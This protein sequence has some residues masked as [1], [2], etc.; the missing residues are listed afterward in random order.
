MRRDNNANAMDF[1]LQAT[2]KL[3][4]LGLNPAIENLYPIVEYPVPKGTQS[5]SSLIKWD[6]SENWLVTQYPEYF[7]HCSSSD[8]VVTVDVS[9]I[10]DEYLNDH[11]IDGRV[12]YPATGYLMLAWKMLAKARNT[13]YD[14]LAVE[15][16]NVS[17]HRATFLSKTGKTKFVVS[18]ME[19][20][21][22]FAVSEGSAIVAKGRIFVPENPAFEFEHLIDSIT[23]CKEDIILS[24]KDM[25]KELRVRGFDFGPNF[26]LISEA[27]GDARS[28]KVKWNGSWISF[29]DSL[30]QTTILGHKNRGVILPVRFQSVR[31]DPKL[32]EM[33]V[34]ETPVMKV[35][36][37]L[38][39]NVI[40]CKGLEIRGLKLNT[41]PRRVATSAPS[42]ESHSFIPYHETAVLSRPD[43]D[44]LTDYVQVCTTVAAQVARSAG[45]AS[46]A[47]EI[48]G[49][50]K[51]ASED[52]VQKMIEMP[53]EERALLTALLE[54]READPKSFDSNLPIISVK[55]LKSL[56]HDVLNN[57]F[58]RE[59]FLRPSLDVVCEN[60]GKD[61]RI[62][63]LNPTSVLLSKQIMTHVSHYGT[64]VRYTVAH[65]CPSDVTVPSDDIDITEWSE[66]RN[67]LEHGSVDLAVYKDIS[68]NAGSVSKYYSLP[69]VL[70][71]VTTV[72]KNNGFVF[73]IFR[74]RVTRAESFLRPSEL[75]SSRLDEFIDEA[76]KLGLVV[77]SRKSDSLA[78]STVLLR[79]PEKA[80]LS[81]QAI[82]QVSGSDFNWVED[83]KSAIKDHQCK[84]IGENIWLVAQEPESNGILG[85]VTC[86]RQESGG[87]R[88]RCIFDCEK[89]SVDLKSALYCDILQADLVQNVIQNGVR[90]SYRHINLVEKYSNEVETEHA[91]LS[92]LTRGDLSTLKWVEAQHKHWAAGHVSEQLAH[93]YFAPINFRDV[94]LATGKLPPDALPGDMALQ[95]CILGL[96]FA[97]RDATG[98]RIM[99]MVPCKGLAT[100]VVLRDPDFIWSIPDTWSMEEAATVPV[101]YSTAYYALIV[102][103]G[104]QPG[105]SV[106][107]HS[108][109]GGVGQ[110]AI[111]IC[112]SMGCL[113][114]TTIGSQDKRNVLKQA[115]PELQERNFANSRDT[116][117]EQHIL[118]ET[119]G[120][121][122][123]LVLNS[124][125]EE[126]LQASV[127]CLAQD[128]RFLEIGKYDLSQNNPLGMSAFLKNISFHGILLETLF[129]TR[130]NAAP[131]AVTR[132][133]LV[134][135]L[136]REGIDT[137][138]VR[139]L[140]RTIFTKE[141]SEEAFRYMA[142][143]KHVGK[144]I[145]RLQEEETQST[146][147]PSSILVSAISRTV[148][149]RVK[150]AYQKLTIKRLE[151]FGVNVILSNVNAST[152][153]G[154]SELIKIAT[155]LGPVGG[156]FNT[157]LV[158]RDSSFDNQSAETFQDVCAPK[159]NAT[160]NLDKVTRARCPGLD[161][162][163]CF[164]SISCGRGNAGQTNYGFANSVMERICEARQQEGLPAIA[165]QWG[166]IG[167][168]GVVAET[169]GNDAIINCY[170]AQR[171]PSCLSALDR[172]LQSSYA[173]TSSYI[174][175]ETS[176]SPSAIKKID[177]LGVVAHILG[178]KNVSTLS[179]QSALSDLG[180]DSLM[181]VE[182]KQT[183]ERDYDVFLPMAEIRA[184][185]VNDLKKLGKDSSA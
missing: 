29:V 131:A 11:C 67:P 100:T 3:Y 50:T 120:L 39:I 22:D 6:H 28:A 107:I 153:D 4:Q 125:C 180:L 168:V 147:E 90:G 170:S 68:T 97:G 117:F 33:A 123:D 183:L 151:T 80:L 124:L 57:T 139:P 99:G 8:H 161:Y 79:K 41:A 116:S 111:S 65:P 59:R 158:L 173:V 141:Q 160:A 56:N 159:A 184:L 45:K 169:M 42:F 128:G 62:L 96:E 93:V 30:M 9:E 7:N 108:G 2:G 34:R 144:V 66:T 114:F 76:Q 130:V 157:A 104:L 77:V 64:H 78:A 53:S 136:L 134:S 75:S 155:K 63:E 72:L 102:R 121:G 21:G 13:S 103:G 48:L 24:H 26:R 15:F 92:V 178:I 51:E 71:R 142:S 135:K 137:G 87:S 27:T 174:R 89:N 129:N 54:L 18:L 175:V 12:L 84:P 165:I 37:D 43:V 44:E 154:A 172:F 163:V 162:F 19:T 133:Q 86:L 31:C 14:K 10:E 70:E 1:L 149:K 179:G 106:L 85:L 74:D 182:V 20:S 181:G 60:S 32:L 55:H 36:A 112:L 166:V 58:L 148:L 140:K 146:H 5:I 23:P 152:L 98:R 113:V 132:K 101:V 118:H 38:C 91:H 94:M 25:Y 47:D 177:L 150:D 185:T 126:K 52:L 176:V 40:L 167:D 17:F 145:I 122:V 35:V 119:E 127:R 115:F 49:N 109:S 171:I 156:V 83:V 61:L 16:E 138:A 82:I 46:M 105:E 81:A 73:A 110:A 143:G 69:V 164:S 88:I 95:D